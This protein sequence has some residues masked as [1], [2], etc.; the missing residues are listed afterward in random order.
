MHIR[1]VPLL[2]LLLITCLENVA[3]TADITV[4]TSFHCLVS[5]IIFV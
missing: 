2:L 5:F 1:K 3:M 4:E